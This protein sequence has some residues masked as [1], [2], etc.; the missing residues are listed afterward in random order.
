M[1][2]GKSRRLIYVSTA[3]AAAVILILA[4]ILLQQ[5]IQNKATPPPTTSAPTVAT[6]AATG[7]DQT[8]ATLN[9]NLGSLGSAS[10]AHV[11]FLY[12]TDAGLAGATNVSVANQTTPAAYQYALSGLSPGTA[13]HFRAW[14]LGVG[15]SIGSILTFTTRTPSPPE[16]HAPGV[17]TDA[18][19]GIT[20]ADA[21]LNGN[22]GDLGTATS[23]T[24]GFR[25]GTSPTLASATNVSLGARSATG[26]FDDGITDLASNTTYYV[27][28]WGLGD[29]F[30]SGSIL[31]FTTA[32]TPSGNGHRVPPGWAHA[33]CPDLPEQARGHGVRARCEHNMTYGQWKKE[34]PASVVEVSLVLPESFSHATIVRDSDLGSF[35]V[36]GADSPR[37]W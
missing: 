1:A 31:N 16:V 27:Q 12:G 35:G 19:S 8:V 24:V 25:Y 11:G 28:A 34:H 20:T 13:Y 5:P 22:L 23:V 6:N 21:T 30:S 37:A 7:V 18:A 32:K 26:A 10:F 9:G 14:A 15:F 17:T 33:A 29:G 2:V 4:V 3:I 36:Y